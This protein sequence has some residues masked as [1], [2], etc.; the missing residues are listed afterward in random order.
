MQVVGDSFILVILGVTAVREL[1][2]TTG[3]L[4]YLA[5]KAFLQL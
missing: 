1:K 5:Y 3:A 2:Q 4:P